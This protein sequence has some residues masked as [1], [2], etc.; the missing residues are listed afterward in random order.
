M[1]SVRVALARLRGL[2]SR[3]S[4]DSRI[5]Q[6]ISA[7]LEM[8]A[9]EYRRR[10]LETEEAMLAAR[11]SFG[12]AAQVRDQWRSQRGL[13]WVETFA[14]DIVYALRQLIHSPGFALASILTLALG[15]GANTGIYQV[16]YAVVFRPLPV[17]DPQRLVELLVTEKGKPQHF[18]YPLFREIAS[19]QNSLTGLFAVSEFP[20][21]DATLRG[22]GLAKSVHGAIV[23]GDYFRVLGVTP[24][25]GRFF[26]AE[27]DRTAAPLAVISDRFWEAEFA[28]SPEALG[29]TLDINHVPVTIAG[30]TPP[31]FFGETL[32]LTPDIWVPMRLQPR[33]MPE[34]FLN[35]AYTWLAVL[36]RLRPDLSIHQAQ[37]AL[38]AA[39]QRD[40]DHLGG[41][42]ELHSATRGVDGLRQFA[43]PLYVLMATVG[44][45][46]LIAACNLANLLLSRA[47]ARTHEIGVR[48]AIGAGRARLIRQLLTESFVLSAIGA[49]LALPLAQWGSRTLVSLAAQRVSLETGSH[50]LAFTAT[51][52]I[53]VTS[54]FGI[55]PALAATRVDVHDA[56]Q[57]SHNRASGSVRGRAL[58]RALVVAQ[59]SVSLLLVSAAGLL[60]RTLW[61]LRYQDFG[62]EPERI[63]HVSLPFEVTA[64]RR[65]AAIAPSLS[66][67][68]ASLPGVRTVAVSSCG[69]F[70]TIQRT[71]WFAAPGRPAEETD[72]A[73]MVYVSPGYF[74]IM[75]RIVAG[76]SITADDR[77]DAIPVAVLSQTAARRLFGNENPM[78]RFISGGKQFDSRN[79]LL[80]VGVAHDVLYTP[81]D[82]MGFVVYMPL[83]Q[84]P[85]PVT[86]IE[87]RAAGDPARLA[88]AVRDAIRNAD[89][90]LRVSEVRLLRAR[91]ESE[92]TQEKMMAWLSTA[93]GA[94][95][96]LL[97]FVGIYGV[98]GYAVERR[99]REIGIRVA[100]GARRG[101]IA[102]L[103][104][105]DVSVLLAA[106]IL[107]GGAVS[108]AAGRA[109]HRLLF[110]IGSVDSTLA[111][112]AVLIATVSLAAGYLPARRAARL[113]PTEALRQE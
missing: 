77:K 32:G 2:L 94:L 58:A 7:H 79:Q 38:D 80:V 62:F 70:S 17:A 102:G 26:R 3:P 12:G 81:R 5:E 56:L 105:K 54:L 27:D 75:G 110:G 113:D 53:L 65:L 87:L 72:G 61:N 25:A 104:L 78:G 10:G 69:P 57:S 98:V 1:I 15:I 19:R 107:V 42:L 100:L 112:A 35:G 49:A 28:R 93:F 11:R 108:V 14:Q 63:L 40:P 18:S 43:D 55:A 82:A 46:L 64:W 33:L 89:P 16:L 20:L 31:G 6:E 48:L 23:T 109:L 73:R 47:A 91:I 74:E 4:G 29:Q 44:L 22:R 67:S 96:L 106:G 66:E 101:Q 37:A 8:L 52:A 36:G 71:G 85:A 111:L 13:P 41:H 95:A 76:R 9:A 51:V 84:S 30:V 88:A 86:D 21:H 83:A 45:I 103:V 59:V 68:L 50:A 24:R 99:T 60:V 34:D 92:L 90:S 39:Y 97:T